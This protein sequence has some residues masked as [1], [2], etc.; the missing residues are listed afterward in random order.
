M[1]RT[2]P[3]LLVPEINMKK[4][5]VRL[6]RSSR[7]NVLSLVVNDIQVLIKITNNDEL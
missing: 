6:I 5:I 1:R 4:G 3:R 7:N 2:S